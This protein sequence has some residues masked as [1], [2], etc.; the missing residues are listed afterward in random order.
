MNDTELIA[1]IKG[2]TKKGKFSRNSYYKYKAEM[3]Q[4]K[5]CNNHSDAQ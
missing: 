3:K 2:T 1:Y 4:D 5:A